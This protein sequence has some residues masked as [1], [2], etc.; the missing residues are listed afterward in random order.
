MK[1]KSF[2]NKSKPLQYTPP[3][4]ACKTGSKKSTH[5]LMAFSL[6][7][8]KFGKYADVKLASKTTSSKEIETLMPALFLI[9][10]I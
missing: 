1:S 4:S 3:K 7:Y 8:L 5:V 9:I 6:I 10:I 2:S